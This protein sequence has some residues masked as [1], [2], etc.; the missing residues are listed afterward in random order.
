MIS[1]YHGFGPKSVPYSKKNHFLKNIEKKT[2]NHL[3]ILILLQHL[4]INSLKILI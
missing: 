4:K 3:I 1:T 2:I